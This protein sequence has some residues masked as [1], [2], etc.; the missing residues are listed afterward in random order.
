[1]AYT[2][3]WRIQVSPWFF[4]ACSRAFS[5]VNLRDSLYINLLG[6]LP[7][8][9][10]EGIGGALMDLMAHK[11]DESGATMTLETQS[12]KTVSY[13]DDVINELMISGGLVR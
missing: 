9:Q 13:D 7:S 11:A 4:E 10:G 5:E 3:N 6:V 12:Q 1:M 8:S 2:D